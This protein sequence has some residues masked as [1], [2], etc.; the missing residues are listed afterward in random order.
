MRSIYTLRKNELNARLVPFYNEYLFRKLKL[1]SY[2]QK[3]IIKARLLKIFERLFTKP[4]DIIVAIGNF[5]QH[6]RRKYK[7]PVKRKGLRILF[8]K[9]GNNL[10]Q[11][12]EFRNSYW[13]CSAC[14]GECK[15]FRMCENPKPYHTGSILRHGL[16]RGKTCPR[17]WN[18]DKNTASN[19]WKV[20]VNAIEGSIF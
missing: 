13:R 2:I 18:R 9:A 14:G 6:K 12:D 5:G 4:T 11:V 16:V 17:L 10:Y 19:L 1:G 20:A 15:T 8:R 3:Q 7:E